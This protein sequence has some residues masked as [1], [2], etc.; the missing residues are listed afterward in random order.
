MEHTWILQS[1]RVRV[2]LFTFIIRMLHFKN[3][4]GFVCAAFHWKLAQ[5]ELIV[6]FR[7]IEN[8]LVLHN[9]LIKWYLK[10]VWFSILIYAC[11]VYV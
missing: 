8:I 9:T 1:N 6:H 3:I 7:I 10:F 5:K 4:Y 11:I 2:F